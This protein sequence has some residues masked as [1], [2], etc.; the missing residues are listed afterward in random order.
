MLFHAKLLAG[1]CPNCS[2]M[3]FAAAQRVVYRPGKDL[4]ELEYRLEMY[5][6]LHCLKYTIKRTKQR[7][8]LCC[9]K[10]VVIRF[11]PFS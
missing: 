3:A 8:D 9:G 1:H 2:A 7:V 11:T 4:K 6:L 10:D 5:T